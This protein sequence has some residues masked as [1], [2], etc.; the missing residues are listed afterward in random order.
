MFREAAR[1]GTAGFVGDDV[2]EFG[3][4]GFSVTKSS[5]RCTSGL[6][7]SIRSSINGTP[8]TCRRDPAPIPGHV[9]RR[10]P[11]LSDPALG[12][13]AGRAAPLRSNSDQL[14]SQR[15]VA[16]DIRARWRMT[17]H[18]AVAR[19]A[20]GALTGCL[21]RRRLRR[22]Q[23]ETVS[24]GRQRRYWPSPSSST[25]CSFGRGWSLQSER[26]P[27][28]NERIS[29]FFVPRSA[30]RVA[31]NLAARGRDRPC[32]PSRLHGCAKIGSE[33]HSGGVERPVTLANA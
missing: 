25:C 4:W 16:G 27:V 24:G 14:A 13:D 31:S 11:P 2:A 1:Q 30:A 18:L 22:C 7:S 6:L 26:R 33:L 29:S 32:R 3:P 10:R 9:S 28:S 19:S 23:H 15:R 20:H 8:T 12:R 5:S 21:A 17:A